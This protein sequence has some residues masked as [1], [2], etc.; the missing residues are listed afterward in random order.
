MVIKK[1]LTVDDDP[2]TLKLLEQHLVG[3]GYQV[4]QAK[5][6]ATAIATAREQS[7]DL[8]LLDITMP[9]MDGGQIAQELKKNLQTKNV[10]IIFLTG[11]LSREEEIEKGG[12]I[13]GNVFIAKPYDPSELLAAIKRVII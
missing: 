4:L 5:D 6:G 2:V 8:I 12:V 13:G 1:I 3:A 7:P 9:G 11:I 10:P